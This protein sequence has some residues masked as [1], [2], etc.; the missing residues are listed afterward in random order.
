M[1]IELFAK[2]GQTFTTKVKTKPV[3]DFSIVAE[4]AFE[5]L[6]QLAKQQN[7]LFVENNDGSVSLVEPAN[8]DNSHLNLN[9]TNLSDFKVTENLV[10]FFHTNTVKTNPGKDNLKPDAHNNHKFTLQV[11]QVRKT[12]IQEVIADSLTNR[13]ACQDRANEIVAL[14]KSQSISATGT[15][16]GW[17][18]PDGKLWKP[19]SLYTIQGA[20]L[21]LTSATFN[22]SGDNR[23][24]SLT[25]KG[26]HV[27]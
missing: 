15:S 17:L 23:T 16:K 4:S 22:K 12:R 8:V 24:T 1:A 27:G 20:K 10:A 19:N 26:H 6:N 9:A 2:F 14:A 3:K 18:N 11:G 21:L 5:S 25:F 7:L 13:Q